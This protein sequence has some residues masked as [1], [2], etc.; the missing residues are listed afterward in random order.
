MST[1]IV[2]P[3]LRAWAEQH[4]QAI[5]QATTKDAFTD[6]FNAFLFKDV[7]ITVNAKA[8]TREEYEKELRAQ[9][10]D[11]A[12]AEVT[13]S[14]AVEVQQTLEKGVVGL[15]FTATI[16]QNELIQGT[17]KQSQI[18]SSL[19]LVIEDVIPRP[20]NPLG[21]HG[22]FDGRRVTELNQVVIDT[23]SQ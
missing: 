21:V 18:T 2:L 5:I 16:V 10:F 7:K 14:G 1:A 23:P 8:V 19:N 13:F 22:F 12:G 11:E 15:F 4:L 9:A 6:A 17:P 20:P 3:G